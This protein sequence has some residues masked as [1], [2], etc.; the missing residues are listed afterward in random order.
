M[1]LRKPCDFQQ[2]HLLLQITFH[3]SI[4]PGFLDSGTLSWSSM[5]SG[6]SSVVPGPYCG[7]LVGRTPFPIP[8]LLGL[9]VLLSLK[10]HPVLELFAIYCLPLLSDNSLGVIPKPW[11]FLGS[12]S[13]GA[14]SR[15]KPCRMARVVVCLGGGGARSGEGGG[16]LGG[17]G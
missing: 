10:D 8:G 12:A 1:L 7:P 9:Q 15:F 16:V 13:T 17:S 2:L 5:P 3:M 11:R 4:P 14:P 6:F